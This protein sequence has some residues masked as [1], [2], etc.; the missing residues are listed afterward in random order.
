MN[1]KSNE[2]IKKRK[3]SKTNIKQKSKQF[4]L[5]LLCSLMVLET[6]IPFSSYDNTNLV[7]AEE[8][9]QEPNKSLE[10]DIQEEKNNEIPTSPPTMSPIENQTIPKQLVKSIQPQN[11]NAG[12][13]SLS[14]EY[15]ITY[16]LN[17]ASYRGSTNNYEETVTAGEKT[18]LI[19][20][21]ALTYINMRFYGWYT[22]ADFQGTPISGDYTP[23]GNVDLYAKWGTQTYVNLVFHLNNNSGLETMDMKNVP[24]G[25]TEYFPDVQKTG[26]KLV[27]WYLNKSLDKDYNNEGLDISNKGTTTFVIPDTDQHFYAKW[28]VDPNAKVSVIN[29]QAKSKLNNLFWDTELNNNYIFCNI[30]ENFYDLLPKNPTAS[31]HT[32]KGWFLDAEYKNPITATNAIGD[33]SKTIYANFEENK[34]KVIFSIPTNVKIMENSKPTT[35]S[36]YETTIGNGVVLSVPIAYK[37]NYRFD[38]WR[39]AENGTIYSESII[40]NT[41]VP[42]MTLTPTFTYG[43]DCGLLT[44]IKSRSVHY[45]DVTNNNS[46]CPYCGHTTYEILWAATKAEAFDSFLCS[47]SN[48]SINHRFSEINGNAICINTEPNTGYKS[49]LSTQLKQVVYPIFPDQSVSFSYACSGAYNHNFV[50]SS[51]GNVCSLCGLSEDRYVQEYERVNASK[52]TTIDNAVYRG[53]VK[54]RPN[55]GDTVTI[56]VHNVPFDSTQEVTIIGNVC[57][58]PSCPLYRTTLNTS[59]PRCS[60]C[61]STDSFYLYGHGPSGY[62]EKFCPAGCGYQWQGADVGTHTCTSTRKKKYTLNWNQNNG[63]PKNS[64]NEI[65]STAIAGLSGGTYEWGDGHNAPDINNWEGY[66]TDYWMNTPTMVS[67][68]TMYIKPKTRFYRLLDDGQSQSFYARH[69]PYKYTVNFIFNL[70][71][72]ASS[73]IK[74]GTGILNNS[75]KSTTTKVNFDDYLT[76]AINDTDANLDGKNMATLSLEGWVFKGWSSK[77]DGS[78]TLITSETRLNKETMNNVW[79]GIP[80]N[81][82]TLTLYA[83]WVPAKTKLVFNPNNDVKTNEYGT[84]TIENPNSMPS[85][86]DDYDNNTTILTNRY[87]RVYTTYYG[88]KTNYVFMGWMLGDYT[89]TDAAAINVNKSPAD[90]K[91]N[92]A[93]NTNKVIYQD[94]TTSTTESFNPF[95]LGTINL[96]QST[97]GNYVISKVASRYGALVD[98]ARTYD[99]ENIGVTRW[100]YVYVATKARTSLKSI[101]FN[102]TK[103][104]SY[105]TFYNEDNNLYRNIPNG[106]FISYKL[107]NYDE[108][109]N[110]NINTSEYSGVT[111]AQLYA[112]WAAYNTRPQGFFRLAVKEFNQDGTFTGNLVDYKDDSF[113]GNKTTGAPTATDNPSRSIV[114]YDDAYAYL[115]AAYYDPENMA[116]GGDEYQFSIDGG[117]TWYLL[118]SG[119]S[120]KYFDCIETTYAAENIKNDTTSSTTGFVSNEISGPSSGKVYKIHFKTN[121]NR[122]D[123]QMLI[124][125]RVKDTIRYGTYYANVNNYEKGIKHELQKVLWSTGYYDNVK[126]NANYENATLEGQTLK[127]YKGDAQTA[128]TL[129][130]VD[131]TSSNNSNE[132]GSWATKTITIKDKNDIPEVGLN[133]SNTRDDIYNNLEIAMPMY[134]YYTG[135][136]AGTEK[137]NYTN[138]RIYLLVSQ[139]EEN[140]INNNTSLTGTFAD[141]VKAARGLSR[142]SNILVIRETQYKN[143][144][145]T[146]GTLSYNS[147]T[148]E[149]DDSGTKTYVTGSQYTK[150]VPGDETIAFLDTSTDADNDPKKFGLY[151][152]SIID[153]DSMSDILYSTNDTAASQLETETGKANTLGKEQYAGPKTITN[154]MTYIYKNASL[155]TAD[156]TL[157]VKGH[158]FTSYEAMVRF[159]YDRVKAEFPEVSDLYN[160]QY[161]IFYAVCDGSWNNM[162]PPKWS[163]ICSQSFE[164]QPRLSVL[165]TYVSSIGDAQNKIETPV[166]LW[167]NTTNS[168]LWRLSGY[169]IQFNP[170]SGITAYRGTKTTSSNSNRYAA[171]NERNTQSRTNYG[172]IPSYDGKV[173]TSYTV[174]AGYMISYDIETLGADYI[175]VSIS[176]KGSHAP[177][178][179]TLQD[180]INAKFDRKYASDSAKREQYMLAYSIRKNTKTSFVYANLPQVTTKASYGYFVRLTKKSITKPNTLLQRTFTIGEYSVLPDNPSIIEIRDSV[181]QDIGVSV[182]N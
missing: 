149:T 119:I 148:L 90:V 98:Y 75:I 58:T 40:G 93:P 109:G 133:G 138:G 37:E 63:Y 110:K 18:T 2:N 179:I 169:N 79:G 85:V 67:G 73:N 16:H 6:V 55:T 104:S 120:N 159:V 94:V 44:C 10:V 41:N 128:D 137:Y 92:I 68:T 69:I 43:P 24:S 54:D 121:S 174:T 122:Q 106:A 83:V 77:A 116:K 143:F 178:T 11:S 42:I 17:G 14:T 108:N 59:I 170:S 105:I 87:S 134:D 72:N 102:Y 113:Y 27:G 164:T 4:L 125:Y 166:S 61:G 13:S 140:A 74:T 157:G 97:Y 29:F 15:T 49:C 158:I 114:V 111:T 136:N 23:T 8:I 96:T 177:L 131:G 48:R 173:P 47:N 150:Y 130:K 161:V 46:R 115:H 52:P 181:L 51:N 107:S 26:Y 81:G 62:V 28:E 139:Q 172:Y 1:K 33:K 144:I 152:I 155:K 100:D 38:G 142:Y 88:K 35:K 31:G 146:N 153:K 154:G 50:G 80:N 76:S 132:N 167:K 124:R 64:R 112:T 99:G 12:I 135:V 168:P 163:T 117:N 175:E 171:T 182:T 7:H 34:I 45:A 165:D 3:F 19:V 30:N 21:E 101:R 180:N 70:P 60:K 123:Q 89:N 160:G 20:K 53:E 66:V 5:M 36:S 147:Q 39:C 82:S 84:A 141:K 95:M 127:K 118:Q 86:Y 71:E 103:N 25:G 57:L 22:T 91:R 151:F 176:Q 9:V 78:G 162:S 32:F 145:N 129:T 156:N 56:I 126:D 65:P